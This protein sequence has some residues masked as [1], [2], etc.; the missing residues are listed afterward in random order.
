MN[1]SLDDNLNNICSV[2]DSAGYFHFEVGDPMISCVGFEN[3]LNLGFV[4]CFQ[5][6]EELLNKWSS[7]NDEVLSRFQFQLRTAG[8]KSWNVYSVFL[9]TGPSTEQQDNL[10][11]RVEE[12]LSG[13]RK[14]MR[15]ILPDIEGVR[16]GLLPLLGIQHPPILGPVDMVEE[17]SNRTRGLPTKAVQAFLDSAPN[18][19]ILRL[20]GHS[21]ET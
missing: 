2:L 12:D 7:Q 4:H 18:T 21:D 10:M 15:T 1:L 20:M 3:D 6:T 17:I 9:S 13:T 5:T 14:I 8:E 16:T 11:A 19:E